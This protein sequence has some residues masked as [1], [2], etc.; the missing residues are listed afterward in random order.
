MVIKYRELRKKSKGFTLIELM[1]VVA[2]IAILAAIAI[3]QYRKFQ[4]RAK[5]S[6]AKTN[7]GAIR[8]CEEAY[9]AEHDEYLL[10]RNTP[11]SVP[12]PTGSWPSSGAGT[13]DFN[14][15]GFR[16]SGSVIYYSYGVADGNQISALDTVTVSSAGNNNADDGTVDIT[17]FARGDIDNDGNN[18]TYGAT[19]EDPRLVGPIGDDF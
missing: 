5:T 11:T 6:E 17:I 7:I 10:A 16:P 8:S 2:I 13:D 15:L 4:Y 14:S 1:I 12:S 9:A 18:A 3:P 19:D